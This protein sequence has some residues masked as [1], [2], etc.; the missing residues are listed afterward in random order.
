MGGLSK[1]EKDKIFE[2]EFIIHIDALLNFAHYLTGKEA[3][4]NDL[5]QETFLKAYRF[6]ESYKVGTN[7][8]A[9]LFRIQKNVFI[10][11]YRKRSKRPRQVDYEDFMSAGEATIDLRKDVYQDLL[12]DEITEALNALPVDFK[13]AVLLYDI[14]D[15]T[16]EEMASILDIPIGTVRSRL[17]R[18]RKSLKKML[19]A[20]AKQM[21]FEGDDDE[22]NP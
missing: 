10:N 14:E 13:T 18:A 22:Q 20:Y 7:A 8:K 16:Y 17:H 12:G 15:F 3:D 19:N 2:E 6:I 4:A 5:V 1:K 21:G 11:D 9:W